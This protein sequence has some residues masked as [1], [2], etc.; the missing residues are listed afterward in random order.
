VPDWRAA[1]RVR[2]CMTNKTEKIREHRLRGEAAHFGIRMTK[3]RVALS[4]DNHGGYRLLNASRS[5]VVIGSRFNADLDEVE[6][7]LTKLSQPW[8]P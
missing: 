6:A 4:L 3:S 2:V 7:F 8:P 5:A 1:A